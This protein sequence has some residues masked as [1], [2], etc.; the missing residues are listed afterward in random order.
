MKQFFLFASLFIATDA[1]CQQAK[2][3]TRGKSPVEQFEQRNPGSYAVDTIYLKQFSSAKT[4]AYQLSGVTIYFD[5]KDYMADLYPMWKHY[6][7]GMQYKTQPG[8]YVNPDYEPRWRLIDS[9]YQSAKKLIKAQDT[10]YLTQQTF[11]KVVLIPVVS[12]EKLIEGGRCNIFDIEQVQQ[13]FIIR[14]KS[15][16]QKGHLQGW[17]GRRYF[18]NGHEGY[19]YEVSD[20][21]S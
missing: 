17:G 20:W 1:F 11:N 21:H 15:G 18:L 5:Y 14:L 6:K 12:F 13:P 7:E 9:M 10:L 8:E 19:F 3:S 2:D 16:W 4:V